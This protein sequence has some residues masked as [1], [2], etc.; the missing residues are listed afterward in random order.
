MISVVIKINGK[1]IT[2][3]S[4]VRKVTNPDGNHEYHVDDG[5]LISHQY[6]DGAI[7]LAIKMLEGIKN[8]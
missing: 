3:R 6:N 8:T 7:K 2:G 5:R 1:A 4:A